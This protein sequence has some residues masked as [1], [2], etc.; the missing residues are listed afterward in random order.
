[1]K[2]AVVVFI[3]GLFVVPLCS[4]GINGSI[5]E[6]LQKTNHAR[7]LVGGW[8]EQRDGLTILHVNGSHYQMGYQYG[9]LLKEEVQENI[10]AFLAFANHSISYSKLL[11]W[12][13]LESP[14]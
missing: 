12:W 6:Q 13:S 4:A 9:S 10:R 11:G 5:G 7:L 3:V 8:V 1:M 14:I 2:K